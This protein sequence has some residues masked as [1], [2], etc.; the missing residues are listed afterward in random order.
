[1]TIRTVEYPTQSTPTTKTRVLGCLLGGALGDAW[2]GPFDG[3]AGPVVFEVPSQPE[4]SD[5]TQL[6]L[7]TCQSI[8]EFGCVDPENLAS[9]LVRWFLAGRI[10]GMGSSTLKAMRDLAFGTHWALAGRSGEFAAGNGA[11]MRIAPLAFLLSP[12][13]HHDRTLIRDVCRITHRSDEA[14]VGALAVMLSIPLRR[15]FG[16]V[17]GGAE[18]FGRYRRWLARLS[19]ARSHSR[20]FVITGLRTGSRP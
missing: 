16:G 20:A 1:M 3:A 19:R 7:A 9:H 18:F 14:Y 10:R 11:A 15:T 5:D 13:D 2:G 8:N 17:V 6:T 12:A 4:L